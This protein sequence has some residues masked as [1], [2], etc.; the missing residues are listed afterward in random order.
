[1]GGKRKSTGMRFTYHSWDLL[2]KVKTLFGSVFKKNKTVVWRLWE[3]LGTTGH[4]HTHIL[5]FSLKKLDWNNCDMNKFNLEGLKHYNFKPVKT[6]EHYLNCYNYDHDKKGNKANVLYDT[7]KGD[8]YEYLAT[9]KRLIQ[10][11]KTWKEVVNTPEIDHTLKRFSKYCREVFDNKPDDY[12]YSLYDDYEKLRPFQSSILEMLEGNPHKREVIWI[13]DKKGG[14]GKSELT[15]HIEDADEYDAMCCEV[16]NYKEFAYLYN[17][18]GVVIFDLART[19]KDDDGKDYTPYRIF[20]SLKSGRITST[21]YNPVRK[22]FRPPHILI[23]SNYL[24]QFEEMSLDRWSL[25]TINS[26]Y[27]LVKRKITEF[28]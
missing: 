23:F 9:V 19:N 11:C 4:K 27:E 5:V 14:K 7:L 28:M 15:A 22:R 16:N 20:E 2:E 21:K 12:K 8:E 25:Y 10:S 17:K 13:Y 1:M 3:E 26:R 18:E 6:K 24:P